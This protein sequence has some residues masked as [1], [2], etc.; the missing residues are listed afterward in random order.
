MMQVD[1]QKMSKWA[2]YPTIHLAAQGPLGSGA[3]EAHVLELM[4][5]N[6]EV[7]KENPIFAAFLAKSHSWFLGMLRQNG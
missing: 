5:D 2:S 6:V 3:F 1:Q 7:S 4:K